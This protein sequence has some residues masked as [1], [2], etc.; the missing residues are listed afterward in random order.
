MYYYVVSHFFD[1][2]SEKKSYFTIY[3]FL[4]KCTT[5]G[6]SQIHDR[7]NTGHLLLHIKNIDS[8][9]VFC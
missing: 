1:S 8:N 4:P 2:D 7:W 3:I 9:E 5:S 6:V